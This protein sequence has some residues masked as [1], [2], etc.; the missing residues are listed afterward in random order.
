MP[1]NLALVPKFQRVTHHQRTRRRL[2]GGTA[3]CDRQSCGS[4]FNQ[5]AGSTDRSTQVPRKTPRARR[6]RRGSGRYL[7]ASADTWV[8]V[9]S[10]NGFWCIGPSLRDVG[11]A[12]DR[13]PCCATAPPSRLDTEAARACEM[14]CR[15]HSRGW[16]TYWARF[17]P[18]SE[19]EESAVPGPRPWVVDNPYPATAYV[20]SR[21]G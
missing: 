20:S 16:V 3:A 15:L 5:S 17:L 21:L 12:T 7:D 6:R 13:R 8:S 1:S 4:R 18:K 10:P 2:V 11:L 19:S 14:A 9:C